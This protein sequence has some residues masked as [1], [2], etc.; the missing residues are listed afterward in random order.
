[1]LVDVFPP[2]WGDPIHP[3]HKEF[4]NFYPGTVFD[5]YN[6]KTTPAR[7]AEIDALTERARR[8]AKHVNVDVGIATGAVAL[9]PPTDDIRSKILDTFRENLLKQLDAHHPAQKSRATGAFPC[10]PTIDVFRVLQ[11]TDY[12]SPDDF[13]ER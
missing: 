13:R 5:R 10:T 3:L 8:A 4:Q 2:R 7:P 11:P 1:M 6:G 9:V 12:R